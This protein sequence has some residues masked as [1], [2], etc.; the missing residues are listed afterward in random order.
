[1]DVV[2]KNF[3]YEPV[4]RY[5][6]TGM[7]TLNP[8]DIDILE[9]YVL[10]T[11]RKGYKTWQKTW[12]RT[13]RDHENVDLE[14][15]NRIREEVL[16]PLAAI[17]RETAFRPLHSKARDRKPAEP[18]GKLPYERASAEEGRS[19]GSCRRSG[20]CGRI[21]PRHGMCTGTA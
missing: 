14:E 20:T 4:F 11:G 10:A 2:E 16:T 1:M 8:E 19:P 3:A 13:Y 9:N 7:T 18:D 21:C 5:L 15:I 12:D 17:P 6:K